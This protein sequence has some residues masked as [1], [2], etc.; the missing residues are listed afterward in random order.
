[1]VY[2]RIKKI[3]TKKGSVYEYAYLVANTYRKRKRSARQKVLDYLGKVYHFEVDSR[4]SFEVPEEVDASDF[5]EEFGYKNVVKKLVGFELLRHGFAF[6]GGTYSRDG[7]EVTVGKTGIMFGNESGN[8]PIVLAFNE[9]FLC[10]KTYCDLLNFTA[11]SDDERDVGKA[12]GHAVLE[13]GI[14]IPKNVFVALFGKVSG[15]ELDH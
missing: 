12:F 3:R 9:G 10:K 13:A 15:L 5:V 1:M 4:L 14:G 8:A 11:Q 2:I 7:I 6:S